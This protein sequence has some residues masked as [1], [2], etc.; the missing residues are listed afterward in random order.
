MVETKSRN[1][2]ISKETQVT[3]G[4]KK[5]WQTE[6]LLDFHTHVSDRQPGLKLW[7]VTVGRASLFPEENDK[8][9]RIQ[10]KA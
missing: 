10:H 8:G 1:V 5:D 3:I 4:Q 6:T 2:F 9:R 7:E